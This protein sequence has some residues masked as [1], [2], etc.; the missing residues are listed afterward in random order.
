[1]PPD[2]KSTE[3]L[4]LEYTVELLSVRAKQGAQVGPS[5]ILT[6]FFGI[7]GQVA[8]EEIFEHFWAG[9]ERIGQIMYIGK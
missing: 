4:P 9:S 6:I 5:E 2:T 3:A 1:L 8:H 7:I